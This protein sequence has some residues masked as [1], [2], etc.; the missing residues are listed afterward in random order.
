MTA[1]ALYMR[2]DISWDQM[3]EETFLDQGKLNPS[4]IAHPLYPF[5]K[6]LAKIKWWNSLF[7]MSY[8]EYR[9]Q[10]K[11]IAE[12]N[13]SRIRGVDFVIRNRH[14]FPLINSAKEDFLFIPCD[15]DDWFDSGLI[16]DIQLI[17]K[18]TPDLVCWNDA[19]INS[20][21]RE[22]PDE[23]VTLRCNGIH[24]FGT[25]S[26]GIS[27]RALN[28]CP[29]GMRMF[30]LD[31]HMKVPRILNQYLKTPRIEHLNKTMSSTYKSPASITNIWDLLSRKQLIQR[32]PCIQ[33]STDIV[34][35]MLE[36]A[37]S[38]ASQVKQLNDDLIATAVLSQ[39]EEALLEKSKQQYHHPPKV[40]QYPRARGL[41]NG[42]I[43]QF[44]YESYLEISCGTNK[45]FNQIK[46]A[47]KMGV[48]SH[49]GGSHHVM[50]D[51]FF[52]ENNRKFDLIFIDDIQLQ[53]QILHTVECSLN[54]LS[55]KG[56]ILIHDCLPAKEV[57]QRRTKVTGPWTGDVWKAIVQ[58]RRRCNLEIAVL[59]SLWGM[60]AIKLRPNPN[61]L[62]I[63]PPL[64]WDTYW[65]HR[66]ELLGILD[67]PEYWDFLAS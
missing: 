36:W 67:W 37:M 65:L 23:F 10:L 26:Y 49:S 57:Q 38:Y 9:H 54:C 19:R 29:Q 6:L 53:E 7:K 1:F 64:T 51:A 42:I 18:Q 40:K 60:G 33:H 41:I 58:L 13:R 24:R 50:S 59:N 66:E 3:T 56:L 5:D 2:T 14:K 15:D 4:V 11:S 20:V 55:S 43:D 32:I 46:L 27:S 12:L 21:K 45:T 22:Q 16:D 44:G 17:M 62:E 8:F 47:D 30:L 25:N 48:N 31:R 35:P 61:P 34:Q 52:K 28:A 39:E 63:N